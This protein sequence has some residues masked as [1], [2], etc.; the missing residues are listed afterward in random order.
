VTPDKEEAPLKKEEEDP[1]KEEP[2]KDKL[3][4]E[5]ETPLF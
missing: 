5:E 3:L 1:L 4:D 2:P